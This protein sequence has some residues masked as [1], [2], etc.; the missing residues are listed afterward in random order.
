VRGDTAEVMGRNKGFVYNRRETNDEGRPFLSLL[1]SDKVDL[2]GR[3]VLFSRAYG[4]PIQPRF[5]PETAVPHFAL[6][7]KDELLGATRIETAGR[8]TGPCAS[9]RH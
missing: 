9:G 7:G 3:R 8:L 2:G 6:S 4:I 5:T 1:T